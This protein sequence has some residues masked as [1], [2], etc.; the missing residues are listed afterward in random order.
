MLNGTTG[1]CDFDPGV[2]DPAAS[3]GGQGHHRI[4][5]ELDDLRDRFGQAGDAQHD[6]PQRVYIGGSA[7]SKALQ[8]RKP[9]PFAQELVGITVGEGRDAESHV[10]ENFHGACHRSPNPT[11]PLADANAA[12]RS[13]SNVAIPLPCR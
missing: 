11:K 2:D 10:A 4:E 3:A 7:A 12:N 6:V 8:Q 5:I 1:P 9:A 13:N